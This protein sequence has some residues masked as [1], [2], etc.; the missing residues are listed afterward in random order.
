MD[1][2]VARYD[3]SLN[4]LTRDAFAVPRGPGVL[5]H[6][7]DDAAGADHRAAVRSVRARPALGLGLPHRALFRTWRS[8]R[9][10]LPTRPRRCCSTR[11]AARTTTPCGC[12]TARPWA[13]PRTRCTTRSRC[14][15]PGRPSA[16]GA[17][18]PSTCPGWRG[19][20]GVAVLER[21]NLDPII[22]GG[23]HQTRAQERWDQGPRAYPGA[24][25]QFQ[26]APRGRYRPQGPDHGAVGQL[27]QDGRR[28]GGHSGR[29]AAVA[30]V[31]AGVSRRHRPGHG[32]RRV[33][34]SGSVE[35]KHEEKGR[36][37]GTIEA[38]R[39]RHQGPG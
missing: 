36:N 16:A 22:P 29:R 39:H 8:R 23:A 20:G 30:G 38:Y 5:R 12:G 25:T 26:A 21:V 33:T 34:A 13:S 15:P 24:A 11:V 31:L 28:V 27:R 6:A 14:P 9:S 2:T 10:C 4:Q 35:N 1:A 17:G 18:W 3:E 37:H 19:L 32:S 7:A